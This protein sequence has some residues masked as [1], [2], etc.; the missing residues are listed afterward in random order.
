MKKAVLLVVLSV[1]LLISNAYALT[2]IYSDSCATLSLTGPDADPGYGYF[3]DASGK[4]NSGYSYYAWFYVDGVYTS[5]ASSFFSTSFTKKYGPFIGP[6]TYKLTIQGGSSVNLCKRSVELTVAS[7]KKDIS[8]SI[9]AVTTPTSSST[10][11]ISGSV[12]SGAIVT[13]MTDTA[14]S[15]GTVN[16]P[17][18]TTWSCTI[19]GLAEGVNRIT[20]TAKDAVG[21]T[22]TAA[23]SITYDDT[24]PAV[25]IDSVRTP[26][27]DNIQTIS[28]TREGDASISVTTNT[29]AFAG[30]VNYPTSTTWNCT[31]SGFVEGTNT[32]TVTARDYAGNTATAVAGVIYDT[33]VPTVSIDTI[34]T[35]TNKS[36]QTIN[37]TVE[38]GAAVT[39]TANTN[40]SFGAVNY[41]TATTWSCAIN[42]L[43][44]G[45]NM[46]TVAA[47]DAA[48]NTATAVTSI[49][50]DVTAPT[51]SIDAVTTP[52]S[53][54]T[55]A[56]SGT[57][58]SGASVTLTANTAASF[59]AVNYPTPET[60]D[61]TVSGLVEG[62]NIITAAAKDAAGNTATS[63][64]TISY[65]VPPKEAAANICDSIKSI[66]DNAF[67]N[68][69]PQ[70]KNA[71][72]EKTDEVIELIRNAEN[73]TDPTVQDQFYQEAIEK[74]RNDIGAKMDGYS[75]GDSKNDWITGKEAQVPIYR[76]VQKLMNDLQDLQ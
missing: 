61:C 63:T 66:Q 6:H 48:G 71:L 53:V 45:A 20:V 52:A 23:T 2:S 72:C 17:T 13:V 51:V 32:I 65:V 43:A 27:N 26:T 49:I 59:G 4:V 56:I 75:G 62:S 74:L 29:T 10:Q 3:I 34:T 28:G 9:G 33:A 57:V 47:R 8:V 58:E 76:A 25:S 54:N 69:P 73:S 41:P 18:P 37:G 5:Y 44:E 7:P 35:P 21:N 50:Y 31:V 16:Y 40:V 15:A 46:I 38:S 42:G 55:Q 22:G 24:A 70:R 39:L 60:W 19:S 1:T 12:D 11:T 64:A 36:S 30:T 68:N 67:K 14:A